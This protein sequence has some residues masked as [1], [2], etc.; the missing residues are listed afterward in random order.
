MTTFAPTFTPRYK[1]H[2]HVGGI[3]HSIT[4]RGQRGE[5]GSALGTRANTVATIFNTFATDLMDDF[6]WLFGEYAL[7]DSDVFIPGGVPGLAPVGLTDVTTMTL[8]QRITG[9]TFAGKGTTGRARLTLFGINWPVDVSPEA[10]NDYKVTSA[11]DARVGTAATAASEHFFTAG[12]TA[13]IFHNQ[14]TIK[15]WDDLVKKAR[16]GIIA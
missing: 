16:R 10:G 7:T 1:L 9:T 2:Y 14:A 3:D 6:A 12:N 8:K 13:A 4:I 15:E 11:E 5:D